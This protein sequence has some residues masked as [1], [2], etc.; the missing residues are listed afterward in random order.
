M[1]LRFVI[2]G[3]GSPGDDPTLTLQLCLKAGE[4]LETG[5][6]EKIELSGKPI[7]L[8]SLGGWIRHRG[9]TLHV[10]PSA[11]LAWPVYPFN[12]YANGPE[13]KIEYAVGALTVPLRLKAQKGR[14]VRPNEQ[15]IL[16]RL[17]VK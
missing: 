9:W 6:G 5:A 13:T 14:Y 3:K 12:P 17:N 1:S 11:R 15:E 2:A 8:E 16:F 7:Q 4:I 10:D